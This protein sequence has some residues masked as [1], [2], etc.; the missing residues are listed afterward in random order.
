MLDFIVRVLVFA[1]LAQFGFPLIV[2][3]VQ[4]H[5]GFFPAA[6]SCAVLMYCVDY[7][8]R[9]AALLARETRSYLFGPILIFVLAAVLGAVLLKGLA[10]FAP[11]LLTVSSWGAGCAAGLIVLLGTFLI[12]AA[13]RRIS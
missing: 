3:G 10:H 12:N 2:P 1:V 11:S 5:G 13:L 4:T 9:F 7:S 8:A 6:L